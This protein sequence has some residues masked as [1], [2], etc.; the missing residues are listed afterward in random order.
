MLNVRRCI[1]IGEPDNT[2]KRGRTTGHL[3]SLPPTAGFLRQ[4][5]RPISRATERLRV[6]LQPS[7]LS[8]SRR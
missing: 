7:G 5:V 2:W 4:G 8:Q 1:R 6:P 3:E